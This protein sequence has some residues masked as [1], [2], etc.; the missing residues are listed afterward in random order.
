MAAGARIFHCQSYKV[1]I[2]YHAGVGLFSIDPLARM[3]PVRTKGS[4]GGWYCSLWTGPLDFAAQGR[5][6]RLR[7]DVAVQFL[8]G[9]DGAA[10]R[11]PHCCSS[12]ALGP[13]GGRR[14]AV[15]IELGSLGTEA[16][17]L[18][19]PCGSNTPARCRL[20]PGVGHGLAFVDNIVRRQARMN[21]KI[22]RDTV[23]YVS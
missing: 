3:L 8:D 4:C 16:V 1:L 7:M 6:R 18:L 5:G 2:R 14:G 22:L 23:S 19:G 13:K 9:D 20:P 15:Q 12:A 17:P 21:S 11:T 10:C